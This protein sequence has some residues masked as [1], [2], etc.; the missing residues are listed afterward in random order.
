MITHVILVVIW[1]ISV[2]DC[3]CVRVGEGTVPLA[4]VIYI[5]LH[6]H[7]SGKCTARIGMY[8]IREHVSVCIGMYFG[9]YFGTYWY[10]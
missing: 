7:S 5:A 9:M 10:V 2:Y 1:D 4:I 6:V 3:K 8:C